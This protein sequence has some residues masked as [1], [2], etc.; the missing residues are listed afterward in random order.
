[1]K[2]TSFIFVVT[3][4]FFVFNNA[5]ADEAEIAPSMGHYRNPKFI[6]LFGTT[7]TTS[8]TSTVTTVLTCYFSN[9]HAGAAVAS[10]AATRRRRKRD[11]L[12]DNSPPSHVNNEMENSDARSDDMIEDSSE[13]NFNHIKPSRTVQDSVAMMTMGSTNDEDMI[14]NE[15]DD[16]IPFVPSLEGTPKQRVKRGVSDRKPRLISNFDEY[17]MSVGG[18]DIFR[19]STSSVVS[20][21]TVYSSTIKFTVDCSPPG[22]SYS[23]CP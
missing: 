15:N 10:C 21:S 22:F 9:D 20:T 18:W 11:I 16:E 17:G 1:M 23:V 7:T 14:H 2:A 3:F 8:V 13:N 5:I 12:I 4:W 6:K 19:T